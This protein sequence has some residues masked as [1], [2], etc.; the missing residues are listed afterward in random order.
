MAVRFFQDETADFTDR[1]VIALRNPGERADLGRDRPAQRPSSSRGIRRSRTGRG[2]RRAP[3][4]PRNPAALMRSYLRGVRATAGGLLAG[5]GLGCSQGGR[6]SPARLVR[7]LRGRGAVVR[8]RVAGADRRR[9]RADA[10]RAVRVGLG[11]ARDGPMGRGVGERRRTHV[12]PFSRPR[13]SSRAACGRCTRTNPWADEVIGEFADRNVN[14]EPD[15]L[16]RTVPGTGSVENPVTVPLRGITDPEQAAKELNG[17]RPR[18]STINALITFDSPPEGMMVTKGDVIG[19]SH[20]PRQ[21]GGGRTVQR[22]FEHRGQPG[23]V[24]GRRG[25]ASRRAARPSDKHDLDLAG[26][27][28]GTVVSGTFRSLSG[29][30]VVQHRGSARCPRPLGH[31]DRVQVHGLQRRRVVCT[32]AR[33]TGLRPNWLRAAVEITCARRVR[34][35]TTTARTSDLTMPTASGVRM[36]PVPIIRAIDVSHYRTE[37]VPDATFPIEQTDGEHDAACGSTS[38]ASRPTGRG[39]RARWAI[40]AFPDG[41]VRGRR[42]RWGSGAG[43]RVRQSRCL[44]GRVF[45]RVTPDQGDARDGGVRHL[46]SNPADVGGGA[47]IPRNLLLDR[48]SGRRRTQARSQR[49]DQWKVTV[50]SCRA[51]HI[52]TARRNRGPGR[53]TSKRSPSGIRGI[54]YRDAGYVGVLRR[55]RPR[56]RVWS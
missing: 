3:C 2:R 41:G 44:D 22:A 50:G 46:G 42:A 55:H 13:T 28:S 37:A 21:R 19:L 10:D 4:D 25:A 14:Y 49:T 11:V 16:R 23:L 47:R 36:L 54:L 40:A 51:F 29:R 7:L 24:H 31:G 12:G 32:G 33:V 38:G 17:P 30:G 9:R 34:G 27:P 6:R 53:A 20:G 26:Q 35:N 15:S 52:A 5:V 48:G 1:N 39:A 56:T 8:P 45:V 18:S 43:A